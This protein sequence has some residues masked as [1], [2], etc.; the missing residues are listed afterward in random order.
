MEKK[1]EYYF[2][3][4]SPYSYLSW[5]WFREEIQNLKDKGYAIEFIPVSLAQV[6]TSYET[7]GPAE[8]ETKRN[9]LFKDCL[10]KSLKRGI[11]FVL[12]RNLP[13]NSLYVLRMIMAADE[14][15]KESL[16]DL[17]F[18]AGW[19]FGKDI[20]DSDSLEVILNEAGHP[21]SDLLERVGSKEMRKA[22]KDNNQRALAR[23]VFGVPSFYVGGELFWGDDSKEFF[24]DFVNGKDKYNEDEYSYFAKNYPIMN[25]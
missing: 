24:C 8:I 13:F 21:A 7:K 1:I 12:P 20:G 19:E 2:D 9:Y 23:G 14:S 25:S 16:I 4:L 15:Q 18:R 5:T 3:F 10:R 17:F 11:P 22:I 6:I